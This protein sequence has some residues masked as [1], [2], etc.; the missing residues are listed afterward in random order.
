MLLLSG[1]LD[2]RTPPAWAA[3]ALPNLSNGTHIVFPGLSHS[4]QS[5]GDPTTSAC[6][7]TILSQFIRTGAVADRSCVASTPVVFSQSQPG[8][9]FP[10][11][12]SVVRSLSR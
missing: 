2:P 9:P 8:R 7:N 5:A 6:L 11:P 10:D 4:V 3:A 12:Q 1:A